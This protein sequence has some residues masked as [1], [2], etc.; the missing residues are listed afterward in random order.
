[1][2]ITARFGRKLALPSTRQ[3]RHELAVFSAKEDARMKDVEAKKLA[4]EPVATAPG[5]DIVG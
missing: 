3:I 4:A 1:M 2:T 5:G